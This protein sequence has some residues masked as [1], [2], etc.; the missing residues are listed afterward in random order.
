MV[1]IA[2]SSVCL[3]LI[4]PTYFLLISVHLDSRLLEWSFVYVY[5]LSHVQLF[6]TPWTIAH[7]APLS[8]EFSRQEC[9]SRLPF[10][11][12][13]DLPNPGI[14]P[15]SPESPALAGRFFTIST[16]WEA[17]SDPKEGKSNHATSQIKTLLWF[18]IRIIQ[19]PS[20]PFPG[21]SSLISGPWWSFLSVPTC[22]STPFHF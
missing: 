11:I 10:L 14:T 18:T 1:L 7:Q 6:S 8:M 15:A 20:F 16:I 21:L 12:L 13:E 19:T 22:Q 17:Q 4:M 2:C 5:V 9:W 3:S